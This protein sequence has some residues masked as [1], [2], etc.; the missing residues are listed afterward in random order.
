[1]GRTVARRDVILG[2]WRMVALVRN[3]ATKAS[4]LR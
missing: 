2:V 3:V 4:D 1:M